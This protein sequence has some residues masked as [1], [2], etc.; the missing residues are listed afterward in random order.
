M[1][2]SGV[3]NYI[4]QGLLEDPEKSGAQIGVGER[5]RH[6]RAH[7]AFNARAILELIGL[8]FERCGQ[9]EVV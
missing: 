8:P 6:I 1:R 2:R 3:P 5:L 7:I 9:P 4:G